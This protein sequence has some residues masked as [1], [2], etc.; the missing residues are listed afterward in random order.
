MSAWTEKTVVDMMIAVTNIM[1]RIVP[2]FGHDVRYL[3]Q[4]GVRLLS[5]Q[6]QAYLQASLISQR[7]LYLAS[8][9]TKELPAF[10]YDI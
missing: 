4:N 1:N 5:Q 6:T 9:P 7:V 2:S 10:T 8:N 3:T